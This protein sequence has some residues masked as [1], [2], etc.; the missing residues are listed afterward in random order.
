MA[1]SSKR[2]ELSG[3][4]DKDLE[5]IFDFS[6]NKFGLDQAVA[7]LNGFEEVFTGLSDHP[8]S[9][10]ERNELRDGLRSFR[11]ESHVVFYRI[12]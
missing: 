11:Y 3:E 2:Y 1:G 8:E 4:A 10:R 5:E 7:Y 6:A 9:G 12:F